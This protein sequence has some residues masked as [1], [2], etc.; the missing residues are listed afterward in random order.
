MD[1]Q[2]RK[3]FLVVFGIIFGISIVLFLAIFPI[4]FIND[5]DAPRRLEISRNE[6]KGTIV[7]STWDRKEQLIAREEIEDSSDSIDQISVPLTS[8]GVRELPEENFVHFDPTWVVYLIL[9]FDQNEVTISD[10][11]ILLRNLPE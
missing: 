10:R 3:E 1:K 9:E 6:E 11:K 5:L 2:T 4:T 7:I 8:E